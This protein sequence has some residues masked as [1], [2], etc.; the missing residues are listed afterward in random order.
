MGALWFERVGEA[1][2]ESTDVREDPEIP[3][4]HFLP[5]RSIARSEVSV[6]G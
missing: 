2:L 6:L 4:A 3:T 5:M 1:F